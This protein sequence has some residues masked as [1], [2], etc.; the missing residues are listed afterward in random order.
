M[1]KMTRRLLSAL[2]A[3]VMVL[4][5]VQ[6][7]AAAGYEEP[8]ASPA[9]SAENE[10][11]GTQILEMEPMDPAKLGIKKL[12]EET[13]EEGSEGEDGEISLTP[14]TSLNQTVRVSIFLSGKSTVDAGYSTM[15]IAENKSAAAYRDTLKAQQKALTAK[16]ESVLGHT[17][18]VKWNLTLLANAIS[19]NVK[20]KE[21]PL[22]E[23]LDGVRK[24]ERERYY[25]AP[26]T[27]SGEAN[28]PMTASTSENMVGAQAAWTAGYTGAGSRIAIID[29]G[30]DT[31]HQS[32]A[33]EPFTYAINEVGASSELMTQA[34]VQ[35]LASQ[36]NSK[37]GNYVSAKIPYAYNYIDGDTRV[38][39]TD[40]A[41]NH[42]S[43]VAGIA[44]ANRYIG[45]A[46]NDAAETVGAVGM[47]P[48]AQLFIM[49]V[50][51][52]GG[53]AYDSDYM[54]ALEDAII[55]DCDSANLSLGST[56]PGWTFDGSYQDILNNLANK[57]HNEGMVVTISAGN[58]YEFA[59]ATDS[60]NIYK[61][62]IHFHTG[63]SP[64]SFVNS[65]GTAAADNTLIK[66]MPLV[67]NGS[68]KVFYTESTEDS[69]GNTYTNPE[70]NTIAGTYDYVY[71]DATGEPSDFST[72]NSAVS[73]SGKIVIVNRGSNSFSEKGNNAKNYNPKGVVIA[74]NADG[75]INMNLTDFTG[76]FPMV[77]ITLKDA[78][79]I[80]A[81]G[82][83]HNVGEIMYYTGSVQVT[84]VEQ[85][86]LMERSEAVISD[87][88]SWGVPG[89]LIMK[90]EITAPGGDIYSINGTSSSD[91]GS[92]T[93]QYISYSGTSMAAPHM[94]GLA[95]I[96]AEYLRE[97]PIA[98]RNSELALNYSTRAIMQS[99][100]MSTATPMQPEGEYLPVLQQG[101]GLAEVS[102]AVNSPSVLMITDEGNTLTVRTAAN[103]DGKVKVELGDD[104]DK[105]GSYSFGFTLYN[106]TEETLTYQLNTELFTQKIEGE[107]LSKKTKM[108]PSGGVSYVWNG[109]VPTES[110]DVDKDGDTDNDD[111]Q[112]IL[113][114]LTG[115]KEE[116]DV[117]LTVA[118]MDEDGEITSRDAYL[119]I[120]WTPAE[121]AEGYVLAPNSTATVVVTISLTAAQ[122][123][124]LAQYE[125]GAYLEGFTYVTCNTA[126]GEGVSYAHEHTIPILGFYG[127]WTDPSM[128]D[129][130]SYVDE[131]YGEER[132]PYSGT[133]DTNYLQVTQNGTK[134]IF[135]GNPYIVEDEFPTERLA[136]N[137]N[138]TLNRI[139]YNL[140]RS[141][142]TTG[143]AVTKLDENGNVTDILSS[144]VKGNE[145]VGQYYYV[146]QATWMN[147][148]TKFESIDKTVASYGLDEGD[149]FRVGYYAIPEYYG[150]LINDSYNEADS[151][152]L[153]KTGFDTALTNNMLGKGA[154]VGYD[155]VVDNTDPEITEAKLE[156]NTISITASDDRAL[157]YVAVLSLDGSLMYTEAAP[158]TNEYTVSFDASDAIAN[159]QGYVAAFAGDYAGN[160]A[161][162]AIKV[163]DNTYVEKEVY[164]LTDT[165]EAGHDYLIVN[166]NAAGSG[167]TLGYTAGSWS[168]TVTAMPVTIKSGDSG[169]NN[170]VFIESADAAST[171]VWTASSGIYLK[172]GSYYL[173]RNNKNSTT[174][175]VST[176]NSY[177]T[178]QYASNS[179]RFT[180]RAT[181][182]RYNNG[183]SL[184]TTTSNIYL[185]VKTTIRYEID[186]YSVSSVT[187]TPN[188][189]ELYKGDTANLTA[190]LSPLTASPRTVTWTSTNDSVATVDEFGVVTAV[191]AGT[192][193]IR[194]TSDADNTK[195]GE[196]TVTVVAINKN[197][198]AVI[199]DEEGSVFFS[200]FN[201]NNLPTWTKNSSEV[202]VDGNPLYLHNAMMFSS[203]ALYASTLDISDTS[204][205]YT[206]NRS[207]YALT[208]FGTNYVPA[209][210]MTRG[211]TGFSSQ[212]YN[213]FAYAFAKYLI[214]GNLDPDNEDPDDS[215]S[216][217]YS[218]LPYALL[219]LT[220]TEVGDAYAVAICAKTVS[221]YSSEYYFL[222][223]SGKIWQTTASYNSDFSFSSPTLVYDTGISAGLMYNSIYY[224]GT[225]IFW[226]HQADNDAILYIYD[227]SGGK[228]YR[229]GTFGDGVWPAAGLYV[230][231]S[232]A[233]ASVS[234]DSEIMEAGNETFDAS[235][236]KVLA[237]R[238]ELFTA[239][240]QARFAAE[241]ERM[242][243]KQVNAPAE[244]P[245]QT[246]A[247]TL[248]ETA[249]AED[250]TET[251]AETEPTE[252]PAETEAPEIPVEVTEAAD[253]TPAEPEETE[254]EPAETEAPEDPSEEAPETKSEEAGA[255]EEVTEAPAE[256]EEETKA[257][258]P[259]EDAEEPAEPEAEA[260]EPTAEAE[261]TEAEETTEEVF[262]DPA[263]SG[264]LNLARVVSAPKEQISD[265]SAQK[266][267]TPS[268]TAAD[269]TYTVAIYEEEAVNNGLYAFS[270][271]PNELEFVKVQ[272]DL[273]YNSI[274]VDE[275]TDAEKGV[276]WFAFASSE[277]VA[278]NDNI[279]V[280][281]FKVKSSEE[282]MTMEVDTLERNEDVVELV[283]SEV[284]EVPPLS[285]EVAP[286]FERHS[287]V[288]S[289]QIGVNFFLNLPEIE[290]VDYNNSYVEFTISG[291]DGATTID[292]YD[293]NDKNPSGEYYGFT[294]YINSIQMAETITAV[295]H[296]GEGETVTVT[297]TYSVKEY[298]E[299]FEQRVEENPTAF[300]EKMVEIIKAMADYGHYVQPFLS[301]TR[302]WVIGDDYAEMDKYYTEAETYNFSEVLSA[303]DTYKIQRD[304]EDPDI[305][306]ITHAL[307][308]DSGT[309]IFVYFKPVSDYTGTITATVD[310]QA[311]TVIEE[312][313]RYRVAVTGI[314]A[315]KLGDT[316]TVIATTANGSATV[317]VSAL[318][319]VQG[320]LE[321][322]TDEKARNAV[323]AIYYYYKAAHEYIEQ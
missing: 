43:H 126:D 6:L 93:D 62:D 258:E 134:V 109:D 229:A 216:A 178:W 230:N 14:D 2:L 32:F 215:S 123:E 64:G 87:F 149:R 51:G 115:L 21:I 49:K 282:G 139:A 46:H 236:L 167:Y 301:E 278:A 137:S 44:A 190:K 152:L 42:G 4:S 293:P 270:Y 248:A 92:G 124:F 281:T 112:A 222:D 286:S 143:F 256:T 274:N 154:F 95:A 116:T 18:D 280:F 210:G 141:A 106:L 196:C 57:D 265:A 292:T 19:V 198:N 186:P 89:S 283:D 144:L 150:M 261:P 86:M 174:L 242:A 63:G 156:G 189:V 68:Q 16:I 69:E 323:A 211:M 315:H 182:L 157:A 231:G 197:L 228:F 20:V 103:K 205:I 199:W 260:E 237:S 177:N 73:L 153:D 238:D 202:T 235:T 50:F 132:L 183:F 184:T 29:T 38:D 299:A 232:V 26:A 212:G 209:F 185:Y 120:D 217:L 208:E 288:L 307:S 142:G 322:S 161:A 48:D 187:V 97:N 320:I 155:F 71:I 188:T 267:A 59:M 94:A 85:E 75:T 145:V 83:A 240:I 13:E 81:G 245:A 114:Y 78:N 279:A 47:A 291:K 113:D 58:S 122:R 5:H 41:G 88:S 53:G 195:Y 65:L 219:D 300:N 220:T 276:I 8:S 194:A 67:F 225:Y 34:Q 117:D 60:R 227:V 285:V 130:M 234:G 214:L 313:G 17:L 269:G 98:G 165:L 271:N 318:S 297:D 201:A 317:V 193:T 110:H 305:E 191:A 37:T 255:P 206:V 321:N 312:A 221:S 311:A 173:R 80:K 30:I 23:R 284:L 101:A 118:D 268:D 295:F 77:S 172:N 151:G 176:T 12:G 166:T 56:A 84:N 96:V 246:E 45:S 11:D 170:K 192:T 243:A 247:E 129:N 175:Q 55:L 105:T 308:L 252:A 3:A 54:V 309:D 287:L 158:G 108:L 302:G 99:L 147:I 169:T 148:M 263:Y 136:I 204:I 171:S 218:G 102:K 140:I 310:G 27:G 128:F 7:S 24:V 35:A 241:A 314:S 163:N 316:H 15:G 262:I 119:L 61:D 131:L 160:E 306:K 298:V 133:T 159:A 207:S 40:S 250:P 104:P 264:S 22:I 203:S 90:P 168:N 289:G 213:F 273:T 257:E 275:D 303:V 272:T 25:E 82:T 290:G 28:D 200:S 224:D 1:S 253:E 296:Y 180:D 100:L 254:A 91:S 79:Q 107:F 259:V 70:I 74:N 181:Y 277:A 111:A 233:P 72:V 226:S 36:L 223:E 138:T 164:V 76:T 244:E 294:C 135:T 304:H 10:A 162:V 125:N 31:T 249:E 179:L 127:S 121:A 319:Y 9:E 52:T 251:P 266:A 39:H 239:D 33:A 146:N 66:G